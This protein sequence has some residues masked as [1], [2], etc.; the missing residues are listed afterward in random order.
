[1]KKPSKYEME[2]NRTTP[3]EKT[4]LVVV[5]FVLFLLVVIVSQEVQMK[6]A[7]PVQ[8]EEMKGGQ[9]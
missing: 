6:E 7:R 1:M 5:V 3:V 2:I 4:I 8:A 9:Q